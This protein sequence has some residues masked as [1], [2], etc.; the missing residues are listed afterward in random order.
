MRLAAGGGKRRR[1]LQYQDPRAPWKLFPL[2]Y[3]LPLLQIEKATTRTEYLLRV[4]KTGYRQR[5]M[6]PSRRNSRAKALA[7][8]LAMIA[9]AHPELGTDHPQS[10]RETRET[11][12]WARITEFCAALDLYSGRPRKAN[13]KH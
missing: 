7:E 4:G 12:E 10:A 3:I 6:I 11:D 13:A 8:V 5:A 9:D 1:P 2:P